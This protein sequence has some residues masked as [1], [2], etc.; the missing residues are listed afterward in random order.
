MKIN[1]VIR[2]LKLSKELLQTD[3]NDK[4]MEV[5]IFTFHVK[6]FIER[7]LEELSELFSDIIGDGTLMEFD[8]ENSD[9]RSLVFHNSLN[10]NELYRLTDGVV[11]C[12][13]GSTSINLQELNNSKAQE[14]KVLS[15][16]YRNIL[17]SAFESEKSIKVTDKLSVNYSLL[18]NCYYFYKSNKDAFVITDDGSKIDN[19][20]TLY[21]DRLPNL[22][23]ISE[24]D[25]REFLDVKNKVITL[26]SNVRETLNL[27]K[28]KKSIESKEDKSLVEAALVEY[29]GI[30]KVHGVNF[31]KRKRALLKFYKE[32]FKCDISKDETTLHAFERDANKLIHDVN[33]KLGALITEAIF[34]PL[35]IIG[36]VDQENSDATRLVFYDLFDQEDKYALIDGKLV[37]LSQSPKL[38]V[39]KLNE[40]NK[41]MLSKVQEFYNQVY[42]VFGD[43]RSIP[44]T[45]EMSYNY[46]FLSSCHYAITDNKGRVFE[47][48]ELEPGVEFEK[49]RDN[50]IYIYRGF[51]IAS[52]SHEYV[53]EFEGVRDT[54][55][56]L[57]DEVK[58]KDESAVLK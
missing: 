2:D 30:K 36:Y 1:S 18:S 38:D 58:L 39:D 56:D 40:E 35:A 29:Q 42:E 31:F 19:S 45:D 21:V 33:I 27:P 34:T 15:D 9:D 12:I 50:K 24:D 57:M 4:D 44:L 8:T 37:A 25:I 23:T 32:T 16:L 54:L 52:V 3:N 7:I 22:F 11:R 46:S 53:E 14:L 17:L 55:I 5:G 6:D 48:R 49:D 28:V 41:D 20:D 13:A 10:K 43:M 26:L 51:N 47:I